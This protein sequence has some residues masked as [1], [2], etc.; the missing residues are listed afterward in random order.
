TLS[1]YLHDSA[2]PWP[3]STTPATQPMPPPYRPCSSPW[4][5]SAGAPSP[6]PARP[7]PRCPARR[8]PRRGSPAPLAPLRPPPYPHL[9]RLPSRDLQQ[10]L[11]DQPIAMIDTAQDVPL[12]QGI[13]VLAPDAHPQ[14]AIAQT[15]LLFHGGVPDQCPAQRIVECLPA[16]ERFH[17]ALF[18]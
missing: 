9:L 8:A 3:P 1:A 14:Q 4:P 12:H 10:F 18:L 11:A 5:P 17:L 16:D 15:R 2:S 6:P 7:A 13:H